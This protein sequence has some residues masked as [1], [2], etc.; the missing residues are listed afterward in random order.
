MKLPIKSIITAVVTS[1]GA[2]FTWDSKRGDNKE[3]AHERKCMYYA[4]SVFELLD[5][6]EPKL[7]KG[8]QS[9]KTKG[10]IKDMFT[11]R[12]KYSRHRKHC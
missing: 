5:A 10:Q 7:L 11:Y 4:D 9:K 6:L 1:V 12:E 3:E 8:K 2:F